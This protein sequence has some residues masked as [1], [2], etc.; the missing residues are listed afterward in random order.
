MDPTKLFLEHY[1]GLYRY[2]LRLTGDPDVAA[3]AAQEAFVRLVERPPVDRNLRAWLF[4]VATN[5]V[6]DG[7]RSQA[8]WMALLRASPERAPMGDT[9]L[10]ADLAL[11]GEE[12]S[13]VVRRALDALT[14]KEKTIL[15]MREEGF[16]HHEIAEVVGTTTG[17]V[18][19]MIARALRKL[20]AQLGTGAETIR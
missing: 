8:R 18:G 19:T 4:A 12:L 9:P 10:R 7:A 14:W 11:E 17:S 20:A 3:D 5:V 1:D 15:L 2:L 13:R 6:R 16:T